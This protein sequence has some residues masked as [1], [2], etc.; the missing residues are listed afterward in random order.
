MDIVQWL[1]SR[2]NNGKYWV[3]SVTGLPCSVYFV[4]DIGVYELMV[5][6]VQILTEEF[7]YILRGVKI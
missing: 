2:K 7:V 5:T 3:L 6:K 4:R 1:R